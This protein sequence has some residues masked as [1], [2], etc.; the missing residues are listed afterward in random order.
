M[1]RARL[2]SRLIT[3]IGAAA[4]VAV[5]AAGSLLLAR[6]KSD[7]DRLSVAASPATS[8]GAQS[9]FLHRSDPLLTPVQPG[10]CSTISQAPPEFTWPPLA[11]DRAYTVSLRFP[12]GHEETRS[13]SANWLIWD[14]ATPPGD[15]TWRVKASSG[16]SSEPRRFTLGADAAT[17]SPPSAEAALQRAKATAHPRSWASDT[18]SPIRAL[19][20]ERAKGFATL[21]QEVDGKLDRPVQPE[22]VSGSIAANY[23]DTIAEQKRTLNAAL[24]YAGTNDARYG[25]EAARRLMAQAAWSTSGPISFANN[26]MASRNVAWTL[27]LGYDW[28]HDFLDAS[29]KARILDAIRIR[30]ADMYQRYVSSGEISKFPYDSHGNLTLTITAAIGLLVAGDL[31]QADDWVR[32]SLRL[33][34][35]LTSPWGGNDG[36]FANG[37]TQ[38]VWD[39]GSNLLAWY[40][41][42]NAAGVEMEKKEWVRNHSRYLAYFVPPGTPAG[43]FGDGQEQKLDELWARTGKALAR[44]APSPIGRWY[45]A[46][47]RGEDDSRLELLLAPRAQG[48]SAPFPAGTPDSAYFPSIGWVAMHSDLADRARASVYFKSSPYGS[49]NHSHADQ[50]SFVVNHRGKRLAIASGYYDGYGTSHWKAWYKQTR[51]SNA[52]TYDGGQGQGFNEKK[53][54]GAITRFESGAG[55]DYA[56]ADA[57]AAY[58]GALAKARRTLVYLRPDVVLVHDV[59]A[60]ATP[61][62]WEWNIHA[63][64]RMEKVSDTRV[65]L[66]NG[67]ALMCVE[68]LGGAPVAFEQNDRFTAPPGK[69]GMTPETPNEWHGAFTTTGKSTAAEFVAVMTLGAPCPPAAAGATTAK[70][71]DDG[72]QVAV[73]GKQVSLRGESV[74]IK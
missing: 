16:E 39:D 49:Y 20:T 59:L 66:A 50:N 74:A 10:D 3:V 2:S 45:A 13:A 72:W 21:L 51:S 61:R 58:G 12:D 26:D 8:C 38:A 35:V 48:D 43:L 33:A 27:A 60:S 63:L 30:T 1:M 67:D 68:M 4:G 17:F 29:Q 37:T 34:I 44:F 73:A 41:F 25:R 23:D 70:R 7:A 42:R 19:K 53:F 36:G 57:T 18:A 62:T 5:I 54:S 24:A 6:S 47:M 56:I 28:L 9:D 22:P 40:V 46:Q 11:G 64:N 52:I 15:Y 65:S 71:V 55:F 14:K 69:S 32:G 31:K